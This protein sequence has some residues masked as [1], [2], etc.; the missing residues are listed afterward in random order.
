VGEGLGEKFKEAQKGSY[1]EALAELKSGRKRGHW[2]WFIFPQLSGL[3]ASPMA[4]RYALRDLQ[5]A[6]EY[7]R[8]EE[9]AHRY[10]A[11]ATAVAEQVMKGA[12]LLRLMASEV[13]A[14][15]LVSSLTLFEAA[16]KRLCQTTDDETCQS[17]IHAAE[18]VLAA[19]AAQGI[20]RCQFTLDR[21]AAA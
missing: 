15:K 4:Q 16:A 13:D 3:G 9:L 20:P 19:A 1:D 11:A 18:D 12:S 17:I 21:L 7:L 8:D 5:E 10:L 14:L 2:M 6:T